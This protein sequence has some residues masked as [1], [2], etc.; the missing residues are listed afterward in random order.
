MIK[1]LRAKKFDVDRAY[2][3]IINY[4]TV[5]ANNSQHLYSL[6]PSKSKDVIDTGLTTILPSVDKLGR[7]ILYLRMGKWVPEEMEMMRLLRLN[8][9]SLEKVIRDEE[10][11]VRGVVMIGNAADM[12]MSHVTKFDLNY[13]RTMSTLLQEA[14]PMRLKAMHFVNEPSIFGYIHAC[15]KPFF[16]Q[17]ILDRQ[18]FHGSNLQT[19]HEHFDLNA[20]P[21]ELGGTLANGDVLATAYKKELYEDE[22]YF[23]GMLEH[24]IFIETDIFKGEKSGDQTTATSLTGTFKKLNVD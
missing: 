8:L 7:K 16:K 14:F 17:K 18:F 6:T 11:Q 10:T 19:L 1:F 4:Y 12:G 13:I 5:R 2:N 3:A 9:M 21:E 24:K 22:E 23:K 15:I 20:L